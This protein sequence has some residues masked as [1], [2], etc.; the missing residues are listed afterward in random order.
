MATTFS[1]ENTL[2][3]RWNHP[4]A[5]IL[6]SSP[7][8]LAAH[9]SH[10]RANPEAPRT[11]PR[12]SFL[13]HTCLAARAG[14]SHPPAPCE[15]RGRPRR[16]ASPR[17][18]LLLPRATCSTQSIYSAPLLPCSCISPPAALATALLFVSD[19]PISCVCVRGGGGHVGDV[20]GGGAADV[21]HGRHRGGAG[22]AAAVDDAGRRDGVAPRHRAPARRLHHG[23]LRLR[24]RPAHRPRL[25]RRHHPLPPPPLPPLLPP[26]PLHP[27]LLLLLLPRDLPRQHVVP[28]VRGA[29]DD[30]GAVP[31]A[32]ARAGR[33]RARGRGRG[34]V[35]DAAPVP[36]LVPDPHRERGR[37]P[38]R[39]VLAAGQGAGAAALHGAPR[40]RRRR[41]GVRRVGEP[42]HGRRR[43]A[44][45]GGR[46]DVVRPLPR[47]R[48]PRLLLHQPPRLPHP[49]VPPPRLREVLPHA[50]RGVRQD[51]RGP[52]RRHRGG[53]AGGVQEGRLIDDRKAIY[54]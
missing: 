6:I 21:G 3:F 19:S 51:R 48:Q 7:P 54:I 16:Q 52:A 18:L 47:R 32:G 39:R 36:P 33:V 1:S 17:H 37:R 38:G 46:L 9:S 22:A 53:E 11:P 5:G 4:D 15:R 50:R 26:S 43:R 45:G 29:G 34:E 49:Q 24:P 31:A 35:G 20:A 12:V 41:L 28:G 44:A 30:G 13:L 8:P 40:V 23:L 10:R 25:P 42:R 2:I 27:P 14:T